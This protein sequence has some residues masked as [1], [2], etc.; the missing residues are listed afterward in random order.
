MT[1]ASGNVVWDAEFSP[2]GAALPTTSTADVSLG[3]PGQWAQAEAGLIHNWHRDYDPSLG[4][5]LQADPLGLAAGQSLYGY[6]YGDAVNVIDPDGLDF[7]IVNKSIFGSAEHQAMY[8]QGKDGKY[9][10]FNEAGYGKAGDFLSGVNRTNNK[11]KAIFGSLEEVVLDAKRRGYKD[12]FHHP[13]ELADSPVMTRTAN[14]L[15]RKDYGFL[16][17]NP[18]SGGNCGDVVYGTLEAVGLQ[19]LLRDTVNPRDSVSRVRKNNTPGDWT[20]LNLDTV[21]E[22]TTAENI[23]IVTK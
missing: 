6:A 20:W 4:R 7:V 12:F 13:S 21:S 19:L 17:I 9:R 22:N 11:D 5:Y 14:D 18:F 10:Y 3:L 23:T 16:G 15:I 2:F 1:D 8:I